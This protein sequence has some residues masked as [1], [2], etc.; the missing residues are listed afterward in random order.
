M[1]IV[2]NR[3]KY[4]LYVLC[5]TSISFIANLVANAFELSKSRILSQ[6]YTVELFSLIVEISTRANNSLVKF[7]H[8]VFVRF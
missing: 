1:S 4:L 2:Q 7:L 3:K 8:S 5:I 6:R